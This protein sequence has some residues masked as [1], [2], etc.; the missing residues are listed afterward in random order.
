M[1]SASW[2]P[3]EPAHCRRSET[4]TFPLPVDDVPYLHPVTVV[5]K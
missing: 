3:T 4:S 1:P 2:R 5:N